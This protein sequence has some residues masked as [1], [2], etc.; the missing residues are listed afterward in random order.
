MSQKCRIIAFQV[1]G[2]RAGEAITVARCDVHNWDMGYGLALSGLTQGSMCPLGRIEQA[3]DDGVDRFNREIFQQ[4]MQYM[5]ESTKAREGMFKA[6]EDLRTDP[7][8]A[9]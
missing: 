5:S 1:P 6:S 3:V 8:A 4:F 9:P 2:S 7:E